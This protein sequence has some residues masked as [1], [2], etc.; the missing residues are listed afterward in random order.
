MEDSLEDQL[1][2]SDYSIVGVSVFCYVRCMNNLVMK[3][4]MQEL[5]RNQRGMEYKMPEQPGNQLVM[6]CKM[7]NH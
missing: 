4:K 1:D 3:C 7:P 2:G 6:K 5:P